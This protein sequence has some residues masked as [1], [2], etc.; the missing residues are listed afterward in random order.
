MEMALA[1]SKQDA[2]LSKK[3]KNALPLVNNSVVNI[4]L[5]KKYGMEYNIASNVSFKKKSLIM[6]TAYLDSDTKI[7]ISVEPFEMPRYSLKDV[8]F[9]VKKVRRPDEDDLIMDKNN[10]DFIKQI[11]LFTAEISLNLK[12]FKIDFDKV[13]KVD[14]VL[15]S[16]GE[17]VGFT[18][19]NEDGE[20]VFK[21]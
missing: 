6:P 11:N 20:F 4:L 7:T 1:I 9:E 8:K 21:N 19:I 5:R 15:Q 13:K 14:I 17:K 16:Y 12:S 2:A 3:W 10:K 18:F